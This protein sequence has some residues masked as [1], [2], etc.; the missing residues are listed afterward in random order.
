MQAFGKIGM[1]C[2]VALLSLVRVSG[3]VIPTPADTLPTLNATDTIDTQQVYTPTAS[4]SNFKQLKDEITKLGM[5][6]KYACQNYYGIFYMCELEP[7]KVSSAGLNTA[8]I[9]IKI[10]GNDSTK[11]NLVLISI[12][13]PRIDYKAQSLDVMV[14]TSRKLLNMLGSTFPDGLRYAILTMD[15]YSGRADRGYSVRVRP[16]HGNIEALELRIDATGME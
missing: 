12:E 15:A 2:I 16:Y 8:T 7:Y 3:Q 5:G 11:A 1:V 9:Q 6:N 14:N 13:I 4:F 10:S